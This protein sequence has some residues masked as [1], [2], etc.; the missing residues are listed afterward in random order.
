MNPS[1]LWDA[2]L[3]WRGKEHIIAG[4][5]SGPILV[6][7]D[8]FTEGLGVPSEKMWF[9]YLKK[10]FPEKK[11]IA[12]GGLAYGT[13]QELMILEEYLAA[14]L[15]PALVILQLCSNDIVNNY[16]P[17]EKESY[18][19]RTP[20]P[21]PYLEGDQISIRLARRSSSFIYP[22]VAYSRFFDRYNTKWEN[23]MAKWASQGKI[24]SIEFEIE[25]KGLKLPGFRQAAKVT[26]RI[27]ARM[28]ALLG[29]T[30]MVLMLVNDAKP[31]TKIYKR[32]AKKNH[33]PL[34][35]PEKHT[36]IASAARLQDGAH[37]N[38]LGNRLIGETLI[39]RIKDETY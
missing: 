11:I 9:A 6:I 10:K 16:Y 34:I 15:K 32:I 8:S 13:L 5:G 31:Y 36:E 26:G 38:I 21:R 4:D 27:M 24:N 18:L 29:D 33:M 22:L 1:S 30:P 28:K 2:K 17:L 23:L 12:Y 3:G 25:K 19:Q 7:G 39:N 37:L 14:G 35:I 20:A